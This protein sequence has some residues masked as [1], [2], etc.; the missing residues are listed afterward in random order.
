[1]AKQDKPE[2]INSVKFYAGKLSNVLRD[3]EYI[4]NDCE[5]Y[6]RFVDNDPELKKLHD[7]MVQSK[8]DLLDNAEA[9]CRACK[10]KLENL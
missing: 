2:F 3:R 4:D 7:A 9:L 6:N 10:E 8:E 1:M 5:F